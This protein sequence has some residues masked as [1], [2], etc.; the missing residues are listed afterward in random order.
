M[1]LLEKCFWYMVLIAASYFL[2]KNSAT[3]RHHARISEAI[4]QY[5]I[6]VIDNHDYRTG[7]ATFQ[8]DYRDMEA[9]GKTLIRF[10]DWSDKHILPQEKYEIIKPYLSS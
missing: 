4:H 7:Y 10:W 8:V 9:Y 3:N 2:I 1:I 5:R 6:N